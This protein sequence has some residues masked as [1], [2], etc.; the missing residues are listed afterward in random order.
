MVFGGINHLYIAF[1]SFKYD[2]ASIYT[3]MLPLQH[4]TR[5]GHLVLIVLT[6][7][8][9]LSIIISILCNNDVVAKILVQEDYLSMLKTY[10]D[11]NT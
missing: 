5:A 7:D 1:M 8:F 3:F 10:L 4:H 6:F 9:N 11:N 2:I